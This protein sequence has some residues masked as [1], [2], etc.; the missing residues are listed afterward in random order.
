M[1]SFSLSSSALA[2]R[3]TSLLGVHGPDIVLDLRANAFGLGSATVQAVASDVGITRAYFGAEAPA[4]P[5]LKAQDS[6]EHAV[7]EWWTGEDEPVAVFRAEVISLKRVP[8]DTPVSYGYQYRTSAETTLALIC[9][10]YADGVPRSAS[11]K[12]EV[13][14]SGHRVPI[15]GRIAMDQCV[16]DIGDTPADIGQ[17]AEIWGTT[18]S[19]SE[20]ARWS[21]RPEG[22]L[23]SHVGGRVAKTWN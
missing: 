19:L 15:A 14:L 17:Q 11:G 23:L 8:V 20:W 4:S 1:R 7:G 2:A 21:G 10:G 16:I 12:G 5:L 3:L 22:A 9:V 6:A 18:P 13:S